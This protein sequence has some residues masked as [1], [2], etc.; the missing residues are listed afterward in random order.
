MASAC[1]YLEEDLTCPVC[2]NIFQDPQ[3]LACSHNFCRTCL[4]QCRERSNYRCPVCR[5]VV[6]AQPVHNLVLRN[7]CENFTKNRNQRFAAGSEEVCRLHKEKFKLFCLTDLKL[8]CVVCQSSERHE[9]HRVRP[10]REAAQMFKDEIRNDLKPLDKNLKALEKAKQTCDQMVKKVM[11]QSE[12]TEKRINE[13][14]EKLH[15]F[16]RDEKAM[17]IADFRKEKSTKEQSLK[18][19][20]EDLTDVI[21]SLSHTIGDIEQALKAKDISFLKRYSDTRERTQCLLIQPR[22]IP[23]DLDI[24][25]HVYD[26]KPTVVETMRTF[27]QPN[28]DRDE[29]SRN[30]NEGPDECRSTRAPPQPLWR[31]PEC[32]S[33]P[34]QQPLPGYQQRTGGL[35]QRN[36]S[37]L[38]VTSHTENR[39]HS[40]AL[41]APRHA[42]KFSCAN[43]Q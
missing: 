12:N 42:G 37:V 8:V 18:T 5:Q 11:S 15:Q 21:A 23:A 36:Q 14:F 40:T 4:Q 9:N 20:A 39:R 29:R 33:T 2:Y 19:M 38:P 31:Y 16:L 22:R 43:Y 27:F 6:T 25:K 30:V 34:S 35:G 17:R 24:N 1:S 26:L 10:I 28:Q 41:P 3:I 13:E 32:V 7:L